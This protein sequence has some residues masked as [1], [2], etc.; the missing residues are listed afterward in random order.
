MRRS[1]LIAGAGAVL[2]GG[3]AMPLWPEMPRPQPATRGTKYR[4]TKR[5]YRTAAVR[6]KRKAQRAARK[7]ERRGRK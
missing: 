1:H 3:L 4:D 2:L 5:A 6:K 7:A